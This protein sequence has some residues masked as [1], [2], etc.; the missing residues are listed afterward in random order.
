VW[1]EMKYWV[2][3]FREMVVQRLN[4]DVDFSKGLSG[5]FPYVVLPVA[6][7]EESRKLDLSS[8]VEWLVEG[9]ENYCIL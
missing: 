3:E 2:V 1:E 4:R 9:T 8:N 5:H 7:C 6:L